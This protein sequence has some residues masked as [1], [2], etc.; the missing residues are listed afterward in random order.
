M[1]YPISQLYEYRYI[2]AVPEA[3]LVLVIEKPLTA[4]LT[5]MQDYLVEDRDILLVWDGTDDRLF[6]PS[7][8]RETLNFLL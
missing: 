3:K 5:W 6:C 1:S 4:A 8:T 7:S 2:Q